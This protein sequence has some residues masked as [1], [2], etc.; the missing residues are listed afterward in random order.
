MNLFDALWLALL[1]GLGGLG[2]WIAGPRHWP[3]G[4][5]L[6][7][8]VGGIAVVAFRA[9]SK[10]RNPVYPRCVNGK[11]GEADY[12]VI[13]FTQEREALV[14]ACGVKY[15]MHS[16]GSGRRRL[17]RLVVLDNEGHETPF[18]RRV[19]RDAPWVTEHPTA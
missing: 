13:E 7:F 14:C 2:A 1:L 17:D 12:T 5:C 19:G 3:V 4:F 9:L 18:A 6:G 8:A 11:C 10:R 16:A 15:A